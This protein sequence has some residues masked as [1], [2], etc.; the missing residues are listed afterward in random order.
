MRVCVLTT[1]YPR[2]EGDVAGAFVAELVARVRASGVE[3]TVVSPADVAHFGIAYG[4]GILQNLRAK[5]W[6]VFALPLFLFS[7]ARAARRA[8][9]GADIVHAH[10]LP[11]AL[12]ALATGKPFVLQLWGS[13]VAL[14]RRIRVGVGPLLRRASCVIGASEYLAVQARELGARSVA[15]VPFGLELPPSVGPSADPPH[16]L[17]L[18]RL[19]EE[20]GILDFLSASEGLERVIVGDGPLRAQV[21][22]AI[23]FV[24]PHEVGPYFERA[25]VVCVPSRREGYGM[26]AREAMAYARPVVACAVGG[27]ADAVSDGVTGLLVSSS[28]PDELRAALCRLL[29]D[30]ELAAQLGANAR[31]IA[32]REYS[33]PVATAALAETY[34][35]AVG[36]R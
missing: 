24:S 36:E 28:R 20:K 15:V 23:G 8:A 18:G 34:A 3:V 27:L 17:Y 14:A 30:P 10:W 29:G 6:L 5:P 26:T 19:S 33:W 9:A 21:A 32:R 35:R 11:S 25:A 2:Y 16:V 7:F 22:E 4:G 13:D 12:P 1:S 31:E